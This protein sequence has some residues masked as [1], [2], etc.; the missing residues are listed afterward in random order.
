MISF[1]LYIN[2]SFIVNDSIIFC[3]T[4]LCESN[5]SF[6]SNM[7]LYCFFIYLLFMYKLA[8]TFLTI[9]DIIIVLLLDIF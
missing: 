7:S 2:R 3:I 6:A 8:G 5:E 4:F 1:L 9:P